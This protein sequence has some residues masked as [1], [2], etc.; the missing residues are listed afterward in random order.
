MEPITLTLG[1]RQ[2][3]FAE[4]TAYDGIA[5]RKQVREVVGGQVM[6]DPLELSLALAW[7]SAQAGGYSEDYKAFI[8]SLP[9]NRVAEVLKAVAPLVSAPKEESPTSA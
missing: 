7:R 9:N 6:V 3:T 5:A 8:T 2:V 1:G 4:I